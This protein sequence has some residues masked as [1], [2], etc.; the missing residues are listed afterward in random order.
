MRPPEARNP[1]ILNLGVKQKRKRLALGILAFVLGALLSVYLVFVEASL[2][3][4]FLVFPFFFISLLGFLQ[5]KDR[6]CI[7]LAWKGLQDLDAGEERIQSK[8]QC[9]IL[10]LKSQKIILQAFLL[11]AILTLACLFS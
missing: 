11:S 3:F 2:L 5:A 10:R 1:A 6:T 8:Q 9:G 4:R 7:I